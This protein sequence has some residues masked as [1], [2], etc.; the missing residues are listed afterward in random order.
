MLP[1]Q[2]L[3]LCQ[4]MR[5][6]TV[7]YAKAFG[8]G[9]GPHCS[10]ASRPLPW[11]TYPAIEYI[12]QFDYAGKKVFEWGMGNSTLFWAARAGGVS[13]V[14]DDDA[15]FRR[16]GTGRPDNAELFFAKQ[17][18]DYVQAI[19]RAGASYDVIVIDGSHRYACAEVA[20]RYLKEGGFIILDNSDWFPNACRILRESGLI[21]IDF[22]GFGPF[23]GYAWCTSL[24]L[25]K[26]LDFKRLCDTV[27][28]VGGLK[29]HGDDDV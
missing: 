15:W 12:T 13:S 9:R 28:P 10:G 21:Q 1:Q 26:N 23:N 11:Y 4:K 17:K 18:E 27:E 24:F 7:E 6:L 2:L 5:I 22:S 29:D 14:E 25:K 19:A 3:A 8:Q 16:I 20:G